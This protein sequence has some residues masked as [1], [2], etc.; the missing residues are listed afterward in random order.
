MGNEQSTE[1]PRGHR[2]LSKPPH[3]S[4]A[5]AAGLP[6]TT[7]TVTPHR[8]HFSNSYLV[9]SLPPAPNKASSTRRV[10]PGLGIAVPAS[11]APSPTQSPTCRDP[12]LD[13]KLRTRSIQ[14]EQSPILPGF[15][16][17]S[18]ASSIAQ[19]SGYHTLARSDSMPVTIRR[20]STSYD[21]RAAGAK[22]LLNE[23]EKLPSEL[24][25]SKPNIDSDETGQDVTDDTSNA[26][27]SAGSSIKRKN[28]D[29]SL[30]MPMRRRSVVQTP[31]V[32][33]RA[34]P[35]NPPVSA[36]SSFRKSLPATPCQSR[37]NSIE[38][39][40][41]RR[42]SMPTTI[43][44]HV[45]SSDRAVTPVEADYKQLG[46]MK[47]GSLRITNGAPG[48]SPV[49]EDDV[50]RQG[51]SGSAP[52]VPRAEYFDDQ[53]NKPL[54]FMNQRSTVTQ[55]NEPMAGD[56][57]A[58]T[59]VTSFVAEHSSHADKSR[60]G[61]GGVSGNGNAV[62]FPVAE[63]LD[64][65]E[66]PNVNPD[67]KKMQLGL[68]NKILKSL[69]RS[70]SGFIPSPSSEKIQ[71]S[72]SRVD[73]GYS[74]NVSLRSLPSLR[75]GVTDKNTMASDKLDVDMSGMYSPSDSSST[76]TSS[77][78]P[79][80]TRNRLPIHL[81]V[82][83]SSTDDDT[84]STCPTSP[85]SPTSRPFSSF[86]R[87]SRMRLS[88]LKPNRSFEPRVSNT[89]TA[90]I[91]LSKG[92]F[93]EQL[94]S[95]TAD[96]SRGGSKI[97]RFLNDSRKN[98]SMKKGEVITV[99]QDAAANPL[100]LKT[101][102]LSKH[103]RP[104]LRKEKSKDT[105]HTI[106]S[107]GSHD[108][109][110]GTRR[111]KE[112]VARGPK[113]TV[114]KKMSRRQSWRQSIAQMFGS[115][116]A[117]ASPTLSSKPEPEP[118]PRRP[119]TTMGLTSRSLNAAPSPRAVS[120]W[121]LR[122]APKKATSSSSNLDLPTRKMA[123]KSSIQGNRD[124]TE[125]AHLRTNVSAPNVSANRRLSR[126]PSGLEI[127]QTL[128]TKTSPPVSMQ[129]RGS[130]PPRAKSQVQNRAMAPSFP[131]SSRPST[132]RRLSLPQDY[133]RVTPH[134]HQVS[135]GRPEVR[136]SSRGMTM[137]PTTGLGSHQGHTAQHSRC[138]SY[139]SNGTQQNSPPAQQVRHHRRVS[140]PAQ[141]RQSSNLPRSRSS[142]TPI[143]L[144]Q[145]Q[146]HHE[147]MVQQH[148][149]RRPR[150]SLQSWAP[151]DMH[152]L[153][154]Q[155]QQNYMM[156]NQ[157]LVYSIPNTVQQYPNIYVTSPVLNQPTHG[158]QSSQGGMYVQD[159]PFRVLHSYNSPAYRNVPIWSQ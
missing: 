142:T 46:G 61:D 43:P 44:S 137:S 32:A 57:L 63:V 132:G 19:D 58:T 112:D 136:S 52:V 7:T 140:A 11:D 107:V 50:K 3:C 39:G 134:S 31:G 42:M 75:S 18:R 101:S 147:Q 71:R 2:K 157:A 149:Q 35:F 109:A 10:A 76:R 114:G 1:T 62:S 28:S 24:R 84:S 87:G 119:S 72:A 68:E 26:N 77:L 104:T 153:N 138:L 17:N 106:M 14:S 105:L 37:H 67:P 6:Y 133:G 103:Q 91:V 82:P 128:R 154:Q 86:A 27:Q 144:Q 158:R 126:N 23:R 131:I 38:S 120:S 45:Q 95:P 118:T 30:Y 92:D 49:P 94:S 117:D 56:K 96:I 9:G 127:D 29:V 25:I 54:G 15:V 125:L 79:S 156:Q 90:P 124:K 102:S 73:S 51:A 122:P 13:S 70:D 113:K 93:K 34:H 151:M 115:R 41:T 8:E 146:M 121:S 60:T 66:D 5:S 143:Q 130:K 135:H 36:K 48:A 100:G 139:S 64:S 4:Q 111:G 74:S 148:Q 40:M 69:S 141:S 123:N 59:R 21:T 97:Y 108:A 116:S 81:E 155:L 110:G 85:S 145:Q 150:S 129:N 20:G 89:P 55:A 99:E 47:F 12:R 88:S 152:S 16:D 159:P 53:A 83:L 80:Q 65:R 98:G 22:K 78:V 33:T